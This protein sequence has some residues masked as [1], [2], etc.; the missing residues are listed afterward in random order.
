MLA[1]PGL[2][3]F[4]DVSI[5]RK[6]SVMML[7]SIGAG[8]ALAATALIW[9]A[10][11][12][13]RDSEQETVATLARVT[14]ANTSAALAFQDVSTATEILSSLSRARSVE[15]AC[16][17]AV[18]G[19]QGTNLFASFNSE[20]AYHCPPQPGGESVTGLMQASADVELAGERIGVLLV[21]QN[22]ERLTETL[23]GQIRIT[24]TV[25]GASLLISFLVSNLLQRYITLPILRLKEV[26]Q[27]ITETHDYGLRAEVYGRDE[28]G[29][30]VMD[31]NSMIQRIDQ[32]AREVQQAR[33]ALATEVADKSRANE[34]L[35]RAMNSLQAATDQLVQ[36]EKMASLGGLVAGV[37]HEINTPVGVSV[38]AASTLLDDTST[39]LRA[40][41]AG[42][43]KRSDLDR[44]TETA[45]ESSEII[46]KNLHRAANLIQSFK[47]VAVDQSSE[48]RRQFEVRGYLDEVLLSLRPKF[49]QSGHRVEVD[50]E[51]GLMI[52]S[53]PGALAQIVTNLV[54]N[55][56]AHAFPERN[57]GRMQLSMRIE[58]EKTAVLEYRDDGIGIAEA[59]LG[60]IFDPFYTTK[61]GSGGSG[62]GL[63][64]VFNLATRILGGQVKADSHPGNGIHFEI[65]FPA[66]LRRE[67]A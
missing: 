42:K 33:D 37:A 29:E 31:F 8:L 64:I 32:S 11:D 34:E 2:S 54:G 7:L 49:K 44:Y 12:A 41:E 40:Y 45:R 58:E 4:R 38:T 52:D 28:V 18:D 36:S 1:S 10:F 13:A 60:K 20:A 9:Y 6:V 56:M 67:A 46:L 51:T 27:R 3:R 26:A 59:E 53:Y 15:Q 25:L 61:R 30:L 57:D 14:A 39:F 22:L 17:Y 21:A 50:C 35:E 47:Q 16:L 24:L 19:A 48:E 65:R 63:H 62:L 66:N 55:S 23:S 5:R 43:M